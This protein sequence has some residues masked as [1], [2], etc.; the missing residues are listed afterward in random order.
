MVALLGQAA[1]AHAPHVIALKVGDHTAKILAADLLLSTSPGRFSLSSL[2]ES[3]SIEIEIKSGEGPADTDILQ[4][5]YNLFEN[6]S[7]GCTAAALRQVIQV[8]NYVGADSLVDGM[9]HQ[10][11]RY[12]GECTKCV[13]LLWIRSRHSHLNYKL[14]QHPYT[15][16]CASCTVARR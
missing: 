5:I 8:C 7:R 10:Y 12:H 16:R 13:V 3:S 9:L 15:P 4:A 14:V 1:A 2:H 6:S 11:M